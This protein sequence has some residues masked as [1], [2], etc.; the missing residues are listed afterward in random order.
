MRTSS[1]IQ[2]IALGIT[3][4]GL[5]ASAAF[6]Q[7]LP[8]S[9]AGAGG[10]EPMVAKAK[11]EGALLIYG[12]PSEDKIS[13]W[14]KPFTEKYR[15]PVQYY[16]AP[17]NPLFQRFAQEQQVGKTQADLLAISDHNILL[18]MINRNWVADYAPRNA[19][20]F[21]PETIIAQKAYPLY[22]TSQAI[23]WN[24]RVVPADLQEKL[25]ADPFG[26]LLDP[27]FKDKIAVVT[28][29][30]GGPQIAQAANIVFN[31]GD[32]YGWGYFQKLAAQRP[33][34]MNSTPNVL[35]A[36]I[37]G[38]Y[39]ATPDANPS[40]FAPKAVDGAPIAFRAPDV[41]SA[42]EF[43]LSVVQGAP[44]P[45]AARLFSEW[46]TSLDAQA[47]LANITGS[48]V[49]IRG[50]NDTRAVKKLPWYE[51]TKKFWYGAATDPRLQGDNLKEFY[52]KW[53]DI[54]KK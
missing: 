53:L 50:W 35:D 9:V 24:T 13:E 39:W 28:V 34:V 14:V 19:G 17:T 30:A 44:H 21:P 33:T 1:F 43:T 16:R 42:T 7:T 5:S 3:I 54:F 45:Y 29:T 46:A 32:K 31:L 47:S 51:P 38:D 2:R 20:L 11:S 10:F 15:I 27:R 49:V 25:K 6:G 8:P 4:A 22:L 26:A 23:G 12:A 48:D 37:A 36:I 18:D 40:V 52:R 41:A